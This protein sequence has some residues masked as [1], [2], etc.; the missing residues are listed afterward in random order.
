MNDPRALDRLTAEI[1][2]CRACP[3]LLAWREKAAVEKAG[4]KVGAAAEKS[5]EQAK[6]AAAPKK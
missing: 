1:I 4:G 5:A 2:S 3:R 6:T